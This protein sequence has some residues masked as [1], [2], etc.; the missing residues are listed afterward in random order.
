MKNIL[1]EAKRLLRMP[2]VKTKDS[3]SKVFIV[4]PKIVSAGLPEI[5][6]YKLITGTTVG[7]ETDNRRPPVPE[8]VVHQWLSQTVM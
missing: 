4:Y 7:P 5:S 1:D 3:N 2:L 6:L 8:R